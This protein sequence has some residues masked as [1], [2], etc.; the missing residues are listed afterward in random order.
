[1]SEP[2]R[3][4]V[5]RRAFAWEPDTDT[6]IAAACVLAFW[7]VYYVG[8]RPG[9]SWALILGVIAVGTIVPAWVVFGVRREGWVR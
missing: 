5:R 1:M 3:T 8:T 6:A 7:G 4:S 2:Q 9:L